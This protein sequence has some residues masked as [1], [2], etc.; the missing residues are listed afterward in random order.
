MLPADVLEL[1]RIKDK[2]QLG[3]HSIPAYACT[4][5]ITR[6]SLVNRRLFFQKLDEFKLEI[7]EIGDKELYAKSASSAFQDTPLG[8]MIGRGLIST[9]MFSRIAKVVF[10]DPGTHFTYAGEKR[11]KGRKA[12]Q[13][14]F[15]ILPMF[16][17]Y[18]LSF[19]GHDADCGVRGSF[20]ADAET[21]D[22]IRIHVEATEMPVVLRV[23]SAITDLN[24]NRAAIGGKSF[25]IPSS[26]EVLITMQNG[27]EDKNEVHF[28]NCRK[29]GV[30]STLSFQ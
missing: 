21:L 20:W 5:T 19:S 8:E 27:E 25:L 2:I 26:S 9:G 12:V 16:A 22:L 14:N 28:S 11:I 4:E 24:Y 15:T 17:K 29:Y 18:R 23:R 10:T 7:A 30:E 3:L 6:S 1:A 13:Y